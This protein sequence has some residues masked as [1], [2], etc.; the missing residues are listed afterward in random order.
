MRG[1]FF[2]MISQSYDRIIC[3]KKLFKMMKPI[4]AV[5]NALKA[6]N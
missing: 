6:D 3:I 4:R 1:N 5:K 2:G